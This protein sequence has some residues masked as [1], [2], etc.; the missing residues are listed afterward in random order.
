MG[1]RIRASLFFSILLLALPLSSQSLLLDSRFQK[2]NLIGY[3]E[4]YE[5]DQA[6]L[7]PA[8]LSNK[9]LVFQ[10]VSKVNLGYSDSA[11][12]LRFN[13]TN[14]EKNSKLV[15]YE[16]AYPLID[17]IEVFV[18]NLDTGEMQTLSSGDKLPFGTREIRHQNFIFPVRLAP[19]TEYRFLVRILTE[20]SVQ[21][22]MT[23]WSANE[24]SNHIV[25]EQKTFGLYY[26][27][28]IAMMAY[29]FF[30]FIG[31]RDR[32]YLFYVLFLTG[33]VLFQAC[34]NG[35]AFQYLW[36][37]SIWWANSS[38]PFFM[39]FGG[40]WGAQF[41]R[42]F[43]RMKS[44]HPLLDRILLSYFFLGMISSVLS[45]GL[46]FSIGIKLAIAYVFFMV[47]L[48]ISSGLVSI[49]KGYRAARFYLSA[50]IFLLLGIVTYILKTL[51]LFPSNFVTEYSIQFGSSFEVVLLSL[52][53]A[54][55][56][57]ILK[58]EKEE[59]QKKLIESQKEALKKQTVMTQSFERFVP[60][61]F[62]NH[63]G[64]DDISDIR[65]GDQARKEMTIF[66]SDIRHFTK[67]SEKMDPKDNFNFLNSYLKRMNPLVIQNGGFVDKFI[68]DAI[69]ALFPE[70]GEDALR[71]AIEMQSEVRLYNHHRL[72][73]GY[74]PIKIGIGIHTG[75]LMLGTIGTEERME[76]TVISDTVNLA[77]R[78][79]GLT[80]KFDSSILI[81][82]KT[83][84]TIPDPTRYKMRLIGRAKVKGKE[85]EIVIFDVY[86][87]LSQFQIDLRNDTKYE[88][89]K[90]VTN[91][92]LKQFD[93]AQDSFAS[94]LKIDPTDYAAEIYLKALRKTSTLRKT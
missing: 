27:I 21:F 36:P 35:L 87:G 52:A 8:D 76:G 31:T 14:A 91:F 79:E 92:L 55:R 66:F 89:E 54:D 25:D 40:G 41:S 30:L 63:L 74:E 17:S 46:N 12:W 65:L 43:L 6:S 16:L 18:K 2:S 9:E 85:D 33:Y 69:M 77:S 62:L 22:P 53:L 80:K 50:W 3:V 1:F 42:E 59:A 37:D 44:Y 57:N 58:K 75:H 61:Q 13:V 93:R 60:K 94:V 48:L 34:L 20:S 68:G 5:D 64:K 51:T 49:F 72:K 90:G 10:K 39:F 24:F 32:S 28:M 38:L 23:L 73:T 26:G 15:L 88:F 82:E 29:N 83:L 71:A 45:L 84:Q 11:H 81:S 7:K 70:S 67:L 78:I 86:E 4:R 19:Q 56:I 47:V